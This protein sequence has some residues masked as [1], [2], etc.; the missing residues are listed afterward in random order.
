MTEVIDGN[1]PDP[2]IVDLGPSAPIAVPFAGTGEPIPGP[3]GP[4][5]PPGPRGPEGPPGPEGPEGPQGERGPEGP[6]GPPGADG[7]DG[8]VQSIVAGNNVTVDDS[9]PANPIISSTGGGGG[10]EQGPPGDDGLSAYELAVQE[11]FSGSLEDWLASLV[12]PEGPEGPEGP[13][14]PQGEPGEPGADGQDGEQGPPGEKG[15]PGQDGEPGADGLSAY[16]VAVENGFE[17]TEQAWLASLVGPE[18][19]EGPE[20]PQGPQ[21]PSGDDGEQ[22]PPGADGHSPVI[23]WDDTTIVVD[24]APGP[25]LQGSQGEPGEPGQDGVPGPPG[26]DGLSAYEVAVEN[27]FVG[28]EQEWLDS[29]VGPEGPQGP[30]GDGDGGLVPEIP[31]TGGPFWLFAGAG[32]ET[33]A[34]VGS[35]IARNFLLDLSGGADGQ[36]IARDVPGGGIKWID[37]PSSP[38][39]V[40]AQPAGEYVESASI[41]RIVTSSDPDEPLENGDLLLVHEPVSQFYTDFS[42]YSTGSAPPDWTSR[43]VPISAVSVEA[44]SEGVSDRALRLTLP[45]GVNRTFLSWDAMGEHKNVEMVGRYRIVSGGNSPSFVHPGFC[46]RGSGSAGTEQGYRGF[47]YRYQD[48]A[49]CSVQGYED[50]PSDYSQSF[51]TTDVVPNFSLGGWHWIKVRVY[52]GMIYAK[53]WREPNTE[54]ADWQT[55]HPVAKPDPGLLGL[56]GLDECTVEWS[57]V[58][59]GINGHAAPKEPL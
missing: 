18:G 57:W 35:A 24:G 4:E 10:G 41:R 40:G 25:D 19:P 28:S 52:A 29:L 33:G 11:G 9:D 59:V 32:N 37:A 49:R 58:G 38:E 22:G 45:S 46:I 7:K 51:I 5:G 54:G 44:I 1:E 21:G 16:E 56:G 3:P 13:R 20:G 12:G 42:E 17:G 23:T 36:I 48:V 27:G 34:W 14:G 6:E 50:G 55:S 2:I 8:V 30:P 26:D 47:R 15:D 39:D 53:A 31:G 43:W